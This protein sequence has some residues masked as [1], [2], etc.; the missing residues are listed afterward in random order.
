IQL[1]LSEEDASRKAGSVGLPVFHADVRV[2]NKQGNDVVPGEVGE[3]V[4]K[5]PTQM[6]GYWND[7]EETARTIRDGWL[8]TGDLATMDDEGFVF[9]ID[10]ERDMYISGGENIYPAEIER[11]FGYNGKILE[12]AVIGVPDEKWGEVGKA[13]IVLRQGENMDEAEALSFLD[14]KL[15]RYKIP[16]YIDFIDELP[17]TASGKIKKTEIRERYGH[18]IVKDRI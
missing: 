12:T 2:V 14:G 16:Q 18:K 11:V 3:I 10:R 4:L 15:A 6:I 8:Y 9:M 13:L 17:K 5:G 7:P 1:W